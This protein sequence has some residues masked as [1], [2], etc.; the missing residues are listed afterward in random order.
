M[1][2]R[3]WLNCR[4]CVEEIPHLVELYREYAHRGLEIIGIAMAY[5]P[6]D[7]VIAMREARGI[8]YPLALDI[9]SRVARTFGGVSVTPSSFLIAPDGRV[10]HQAAGELDMDKVRK[11]VA[12]MIAGND[13]IAVN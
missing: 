4:S 7:R 11:L 1:K 6:P 12:G 8:T 10:V 9:D 3:A 5:D 2:R 13:T